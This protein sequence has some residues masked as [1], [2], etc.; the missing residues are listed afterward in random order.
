MISS[1]SRPAAPE[2]SAIICTYNRAPLL[3]KALGALCGQTLPSDRFEIIVIDDGSSDDTRKVAESFLPALPLAY[4]YQTNA[5]LAS[6]K[7][8]GLCAAT[9]PIV[10]FM[11]DDDVADSRF[12]EEHLA[13]HRRYPRDEY[14]VLSYTDLAANV[15]ASPLMH[16]VTKVQGH[17][18]AYAGLKHGQFL[19]F[20]YFWGGRSSCKRMLML[21][22]GVFAPKYRFGAEDVELGYR[23]ERVGL[24]VVYNRN[25]ISHMIRTLTFDDFCRRSYLQG[26]SNGVFYGDYPDPAIA[27]W[28]GISGAAEEWKQIEPRFDQILKIGRDLDRFA[29]ERA[30]VGLPLDEAAKRLLYRGYES[31]FRASRIKGTVEI[32]TPL[33]STQA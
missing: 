16:Y 15:A 22:N 6:A 21:M 31:S 24:K 18:F 20:T 28:G 10:V 1:P 7:N 3:T 14:A 25:A 12:L 33:Y 13:M 2:L 32:L 11:D 27:A 8:H 9:A 29:S 17:L 4:S 26:R 5:G 19:D 30:R 23:L